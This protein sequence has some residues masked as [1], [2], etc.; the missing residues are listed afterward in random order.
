VQIGHHSYTPEKDCSPVIVPTSC[1][2]NTWHWDNVEIDQAVPFTIIPANV[3]Y[4]SAIRDNSH[5]CC[6]PEIT[7]ADVRTV[8]FPTPAPTGA[9]LRFA[10]H[11]DEGGSA[12][13]E[14]SFDGGLTWQVAQVQPGSKGPQGL[15]TMS[16]I[17]HPIPVG[18]T[19]VKLRLNDGGT[20]AGRD[21]WD[22]RDFSIWAR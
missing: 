5:G 12:K 8:T 2:A 15:S 22:A 13:L 7:K 4:V 21:G 14:L 16:S 6:G 20:G 11:T 17:W 10:G 19:T 18:T 3:E 1:T 9:H